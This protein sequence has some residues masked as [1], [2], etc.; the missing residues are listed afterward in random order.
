MTTQSQPSRNSP[1]PNPG[2]MSLVH[3]LPLGVLLSLLPSPI[4]FVLGGVALALWVVCWCA[5][6]D[7]PLVSEECPGPHR[8]YV[9][10]R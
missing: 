5:Q 10:H 6:S 3:S 1:V 9:S 7:T 2:R 4:L 8:R